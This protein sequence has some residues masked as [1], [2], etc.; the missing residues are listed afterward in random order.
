MGPERGRSRRIEARARRRIGVPAWGS[1]RAAIGF[2]LALA[3]APARAQPATRE[4]PSNQAATQAPEA[5]G[6]PPPAA[7]ADC[8][9]EDDV[10][11]SRVRLEWPASARRV[12]TWEYVAAPLLGLAAL[13]TYALVEP[14]RGWY[15]PILFDDA[16]RDALRLDSRSGRKTARTTSDVLL[17]WSFAHP[18]LIDNLVVTLGLEQSPDVAWQML[19]INAQAY[20]LTASVSEVVKVAVGRE[21]PYGEN[22]PAGEGD[23]DCEGAMRY[24]S[25]Y[26]GHA[27]FTATGA[28]LVCAHH[29]NLDLYGSPALDLG[30]CL[31]AVTASLAAGGLRVASDLHW[32]SDVGVGHLVGF[33]SGYLIPTLVYYRGGGDGARAAD[34]AGRGRS[35]PPAI[36]VLPVLG[37]NSVQITAVGAL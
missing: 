21:R 19:W 23:A 3:S 5:G 31:L 28:G 18:L 20:A 22:C 37:A 16:A 8:R 14:R 10:G 9:P 34:A 15:G 1:A 25:F 13:G 35:R 2:G 30:A 24:R 29:M 26:S 36:A 17:G 33:A 27:A 7:C 32:A 12:G 11:A 6:A 4:A